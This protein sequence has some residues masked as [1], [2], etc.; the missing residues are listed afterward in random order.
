MSGPGLNWRE[1]SAVRPD[2]AEAGKQLFY[3]Y[4]VG[5]AFLSTVRLDGG[6]RVHP[7]CPLLSEDRLTAFL[8]PSPKSDDLRR[9]ARY[10]MH[11]F[12][13][14]EDEDAFY[15]TGAAREIDDPDLRAR[16][17]RAYLDERP[18]LVDLDLAGQSLFEFLVGTAMHTRTTGHGDPAPRH[19]VWTAP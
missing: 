16:L 11:S 4:G 19:V 2:L 17:E 3:Q 5:L 9:D 1:F 6:P 8:I 10:A 18:Q 12:P 13:A 14:D 7:M 15:L